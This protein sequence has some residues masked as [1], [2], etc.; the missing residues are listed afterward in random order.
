MK[1]V[2]GADMPEWIRS[3]DDAVYSSVSGFITDD[4]TRV[5]KFFTFL[6]SELTIALLAVLLPL[7]VLVL[8]KRK[9]YGMALAPMINIAMGALFSQILKYLFQRPRPDILR[10]IEISGYSFPS[11]HSM[12]SLI[13][14]GFIAYL[15]MKNGRHWSRCVFAGA[16]GLMVLLI[17]I[18]RI[19]L[20]V[21]YASDV[22]GGFMIGLGWLILAAKI[23]KNILFDADRRSA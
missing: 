1:A 2:M 6:G 8:K 20:G 7:L 3:F 23:T 14:Y 18:S 11:G 13:F 16:V 4:M 17:G 9:Y 12:N 5:M 19:Y 10:L 22:L 21:H 15:L